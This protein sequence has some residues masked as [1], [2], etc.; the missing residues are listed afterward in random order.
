MTACSGSWL[1]MLA[2]LQPTNQHVHKAQLILAYR[3]KT[4]ITAAAAPVRFAERES[5]AN[6]VCP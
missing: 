6:S 2:C 5:N 1:L 4:L 3:V